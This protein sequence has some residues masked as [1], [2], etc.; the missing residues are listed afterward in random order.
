LRTTGAG[1]S[2]C[3]SGRRKIVSPDQATSMTTMMVVTYMIFRASSDD[4]WMPL[5]LRHQ[6]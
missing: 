5:V 6:K 4:S 3:A 1:G 2:R